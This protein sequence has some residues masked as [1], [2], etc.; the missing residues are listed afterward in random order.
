M[1]CHTQTY[2]TAQQN[3]RLCLISK[4][5]TYTFQVKYDNDFD[6]FTIMKSIFAWIFL[7]TNMAII[8]LKIIGISL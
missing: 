8:L 2:S 6:N 5:A 7:C 3:V 4:L 1:A